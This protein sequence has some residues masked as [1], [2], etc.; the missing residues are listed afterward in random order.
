MA[1]NHRE[2]SDLATH[3]G[4]E[5]HLEKNGL[6]NHGGLAAAAYPSPA[7]RRRAW[8]RGLLLPIV[9]AIVCGGG[10]YIV[11]SNY[12]TPWYRS[13]TTLYFPVTG[14]QGNSDVINSLLGGGSAD[15]TG[16]I[17]LLGGIY[18]V[19][20]VGSGPSTAIM[21][22]SSNRCQS[23][24]V[25]RLNLPKRWNM[26]PDKVSAR[27]LK[28][29][30][31]GVDKNGLLSIQALD[32]S[33]ATARE[34]VNAYV[35]AM[36][37]VSQE[38]TLAQ[39]HDVVL[40]L[41]KHLDHQNQALH[42]EED[43]L[44]NLEVISANKVPLGP[45]T[46]TAYG[47][48]A[49]QRR[50]ATI[51]LKT[52]QAEID[53]RMR[54]VKEAQNVSLPTQ[55][56]YAQAART[57]LRDLQAK[58]ATAKATL[59]P[60][61]TALQDLEIQTSQALAEYNA[62]LKRE[63]NVVKKGI[64]PDMADLYAKRASLQAKL[65]GINQAISPLRSA[66]MSLPEQKM[67]QDRLTAD[68]ARDE[69]LVDL[70]AAA[71]TQAQI[72]ERR[73]VPTF[74]VVDAAVVAGR[75]VI[76]RIIYTTALAAIA[77]FL[78]ALAWQV[79]RILMRQP[80]TQSTMRR[81]ANAYGLSEEEPAAKLSDEGHLESISTQHAPQLSQESSTRPEKSHESSEV[82]TDVGNP[83]EPGSTNGRRP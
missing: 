44:V 28:N 83:H 30:S 49:A 52:M 60:D 48:L 69:K 51:D 27:L 79:A 68:V 36:K 80:T 17:P 16:S 12:V 20:F 71:V 10:A 32:T 47:D 55:M 39:S 4:D 8:L 19:P 18:N 9:A 73:N 77:G 59:G 46:T 58:L 42:R 56:P 67:Q 13:A 15:S 41:Q 50:T 7:P 38:L 62:E 5:N 3:P 23:I 54:T 53:Q 74:Q 61:N 81:W 65:D 57:R 76:P 22:L 78:L 14:N 6:N 40:A 75:P 26:K 2:S 33:A 21:A 63:I 24:V 82:G 25:S 45:D 1:Q 66:V 72:A 29:V 70:L 34:L 35:A 37:D 43:M 64:A 31:Y 11:C